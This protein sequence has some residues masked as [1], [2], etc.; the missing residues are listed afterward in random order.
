MAIMML[1][2]FRQRLDRQGS[3]GKF[4]SRN[5]YGVYLIHPVVIVPLALMVSGISMDPLM[6]FALI[7]PLGVGLCFLAAQYLLRRIPYSDRVL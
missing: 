6:K 2:L 4:L 7:A 1:G 5:A 3:F